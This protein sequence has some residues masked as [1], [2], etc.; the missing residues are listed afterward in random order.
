MM[1]R[2]EDKML[3]DEHR[4]ARLVGGGAGRPHP[5][6]PALDHQPASHD[7]V[8]GK[9]IKRQGWQKRPTAPNIG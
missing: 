8:M 7:A 2:P 3:A 9:E 1:Q 6:P 4:Q 5:P